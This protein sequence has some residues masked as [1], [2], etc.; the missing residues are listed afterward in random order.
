MN[1]RPSYHLVV[2]RWREIP[3]FLPHALE[4]VCGLDVD[5]V[6]RFK[7]KFQFLKGVCVCWP[8][9]EDRA[10]HFFLSEVYFYEA[11]FTCGLRRGEQGLSEVYLRPSGIGNQDFSLCPGM[12]LKLPPIGIGVISQGYFVSGWNPNLGCVSISSRRF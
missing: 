10:C 1:S 5:T 11:A 2:T 9:D 3:L 4:E 7:D 6:S 12:I 8:N